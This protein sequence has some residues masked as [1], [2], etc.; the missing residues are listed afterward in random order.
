MCQRRRPL[1]LISVESGCMYGICKAAAAAPPMSGPLPRAVQLFAARWSGGMSHAYGEFLRP[2]ALF[3]DVPM[4]CH[5]PKT[6]V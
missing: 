5:D 3:L 1:I 2:E 4:E 6:G